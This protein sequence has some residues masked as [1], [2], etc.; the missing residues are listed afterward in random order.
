MQSSGDGN[1]PVPGDV[2]QFGAARFS[3]QSPFE[4][5][6]RVSA[7]H[8]RGAGSLVNLSLYGLGLSGMWTALGTPLLPIKVEEIVGNGGSSILGIVFD[9]SDKNGALGL[10]SLTGLAIAALMQPLAGM[11]SDRDSGPT[12]RLPFLLVGALGMAASVLFLGFVGTLVSLIFLNVLIQGLG[13]FGQG[14]AN[15]LIADHVSPGNKGAAA[16]ALNLSRVIGAGLLAGIVLLLMS[17]YDAESAPGWMTVSLVL[18]AVIAVAST[19]WTITSLRRTG[20]ADQ[21]DQ[22]GHAGEDAAI[23]LSTT[24]QTGVTHLRAETPASQPEFGPGVHGSDEEE[25]V[26]PHDNYLRFLIALTVVITGFSALQLYSFF[27]LQDVIG[28]KN[29]SQGAAVILVTTAVATALT[30]LPAGRLTDRVGRDPMLYLG[31]VLGVIGTVILIFANSILVVALDGLILGVAIGI[32]LT[33]SWA[34][35][36]DLVSKRNAARDLG[37]ASVAVLIGSTASRISGLGVDRLNEVQH[38]LGYQ[39]VLGAVAV[40]FII[41]VALMTRLDGSPPVRVMDVVRGRPVP[42]RA[43]D[44][45]PD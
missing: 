24:A 39:V 22:T 12:K 4:S 14:A 37:Y 13:N 8:R 11:L 9:E 20:H 17:H 21:T 1:S 30:V 3:V 31:G 40:C 23:P 29:A 45:M 44:S 6:R 5:I 42:E 43:P 41:A 7:V 32:F 18:V 33:V 16:G 27:Y 38:A 19:L 2:P 10:V 28:L 15:G 34:L 26:A 25:T 35:A 36:N